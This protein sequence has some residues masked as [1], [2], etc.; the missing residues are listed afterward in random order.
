MTITLDQI[1][2]L[3]SQKLFYSL[4]PR[5]FVTLLCGDT[6]SGKTFICGQY[7]A[8]WA[9]ALGSKMSAVLSAPVRSQARDT[10]WKSSIEAL[11]RLKIPYKISSKDNTEILRTANGAEWRLGSYEGRGIHR[12]MGVERSHFVIDEAHLLDN[13]KFGQI[14]SRLSKK[15]EEGKKCELI[16]LCNPQGPTHWIKTDWID[17][18]EE[19]GP[20]NFKYLYFS[21][22]DNEQ[23]LAPGY[24]DMMEQNLT[25]VMRERLLN[26]KWIAMEG[27]VF[28]CLLENADYVFY[29][30]LQAPPK[31]QP[32]PEP[33]IHGGAIDFGYKNPFAYVK[34]HVAWDGILYITHEWEQSEM[35]L[36]QHADAITAINKKEKVTIWADHDAQDVAELRKLGITSKPADKSKKT[37][38]NGNIMTVYQ[39]LKRGRIRISNNCTQLRNELMSYV[40]DENRDQPVKQDDHLVD[41]FIYM[42]IGLYKHNALARKLLDGE[43][44]HEQKGKNKLNLSQ[45]RT[46]LLS[47]EGAKEKLKARFIGESESNQRSS[48]LE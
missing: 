36:S 27:L 43:Y 25:P 47:E 26:G 5:P 31:G 9:V 11:D 39:L 19:R 48:F 7:L 14:L 6:R 46:K 28:S 3:P 34:G 37:G 10:I 12:I 21:V 44:Y 13:E 18:E 32:R 20:S 23:N 17:R 30:K 35:Y 24:I 16:L 2:W 42:V 15:M 33:A 4:N 8:D 29:D 38:D 40:W 41:A 45:S 1:N 22:Y